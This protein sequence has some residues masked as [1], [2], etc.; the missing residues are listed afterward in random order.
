MNS[1]CSLLSSPPSARPTRVHWPMTRMSTETFSSLPTRCH[2]TWRYRNY[3]QTLVMLQREQTKNRIKT[4]THCTF[5]IWWKRWMDESGR[6]FDCHKKH[7]STVVDSKERS[8]PPLARLLFQFLNWILPH[9]P[10]LIWIRFRW[11]KSNFGGEKNKQ[12][13][14]LKCFFR[15]KVFIASRLELIWF[16]V[17]SRERSLSLW[18]RRKIARNGC[19]KIN[20]VLWIS[21]IFVANSRQLHYLSHS[22]TRSPR[23]H[24]SQTQW[25]SSFPFRLMSFLFFNFRYR[26]SNLIMEQARVLRL[27]SPSSYTLYRLTSLASRLA[28]LSINNNV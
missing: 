13:T 10:S 6:V 17:A 12:Q 24:R 16:R 2:S 25:F 19:N 27:P 14:T 23:K 9:S 3:K 7:C 21:W 5:T 20:I 18:H 4:R 8:V 22:L 15:G 28:P 26:F 1:S 11:R